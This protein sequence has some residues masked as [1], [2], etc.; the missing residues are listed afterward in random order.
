MKNF[1]KMMLL[2]FGFLLL[3]VGCARLPKHDPEIQFSYFT[4]PY[5]PA[6][7]Q[8]AIPSLYQDLAEEHPQKDQVMLLEVGDD[9]LL[10]RIHLIRAATESI[11][12]QTFI[13][14]EDQ[15]TRVIF[16]ELLEAARRGVKVR[17]LV[18]ALNP[19]TGNTRLAQ[20]AV[21][22][23]NL[24]FAV[25]RPLSF[26]TQPPPINKLENMMLK[27]RRMN[28]RMHNK[29]FLVDDDIGIIGGR[30]YE[31]KYFDRSPVMIFNDRDLLVMGPNTFHMDEMF[32]AFWS[33]KDSV[34]L[35]QFKDVQ[36]RLP[37]EIPQ[38]YSFIQEGDTSSMT[39]VLSEANL[40]NP[41]EFR[42]TMQVTQVEEAAFF[43]DP[44]GK[45]KHGKNA[46]EDHYGE[47]I[48]QVLATANERIIFQ[49]PYLIY[50][51]ESKKTI[52][53]IRERTPNLEVW[54]STNSLA[55]ADH[56]VVYG[57][58]F[59][60]RKKL[61]K[62]LKFEIFE[63][64]PYPKDLLSFVPTYPQL[65]GLSP[66]EVQSQLE[67]LLPV[68]LMASG[69][70]LTIHA[71]TFVV[72]DKFTQIGSHN[73]DPRS[74]ALNS[75]CG[76]IIEDKAFTRTVK[77]HILNEMSNGNSWIV[78]KQNETDTIASKTSGFVG[79]VSH[80]LPVFDLWPYT[81]TSNFE[82][83]PEYPPLPN[84]RHPD[85]HVH[86]RNVGQFPMAQNAI[87]KM[88]AKFMKGFGGWT[89]SFM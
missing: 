41:G 22:N 40:Y 69:P 44:P 42:S 26:Y 6:N 32:E 82:L 8:E 72:D 10:T 39:Q 33:H 80:A 25:F 63:F 45:F 68:L 35:T 59:K 66:T 3:T 38:D 89:R 47:I 55:S 79:S 58:S 18:D 27:M 50:Q 71:K 88:R 9:A 29:L 28:R 75:E 43:W 52:E 57:V 31:N 34:Y 53:E 12:I 24:E 74:Y 11:D 51:K 17:V 78:A 61:Y 67:Q 60:D 1:N 23:P 21:A 56:D 2:T 20:M 37:I 85:F 86:Y 81:Y 46:H 64:I 76:L 87:E 73:F 13:W 19:I 14:K 83:K 48:K 16:Q 54:F 5:P 4:K 49:S 84:S 62:T 70:K 77:R 30:N 36:A 65:C 7:G 15:V